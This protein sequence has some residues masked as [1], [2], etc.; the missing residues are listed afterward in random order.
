MVMFPDGTRP[1]GSPQV[2][3]APRP[4]DYEIV[5]G[6]SVLRPMHV[7]WG[8]GYRNPHRQPKQKPLAASPPIAAE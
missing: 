3:P 4:D 2:A 8:Q 6:Q 1:A 7:R 5:G